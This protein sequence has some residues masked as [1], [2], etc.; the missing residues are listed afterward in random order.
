MY[1]DSSDSM[2]VKLQR[3]PPFKILPVAFPNVSHHQLSF[4]A[5]EAGRGDAFGGAC[6]A[7][8]AMVMVT[9]MQRL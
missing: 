7:C 3:E 8:D 4:D 6:D 5:F 2:Y 9:A 1:Q